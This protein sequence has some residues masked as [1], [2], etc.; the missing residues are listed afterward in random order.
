MKAG[1]EFGYEY[2]PKFNFPTSEHFVEMLR[3]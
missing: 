3:I 2:S 1:S